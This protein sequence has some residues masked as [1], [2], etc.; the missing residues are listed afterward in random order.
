MLSCREVID[1][2]MDYRNR[3]LPRAQRVAHPN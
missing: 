2:L 1:F 3:D